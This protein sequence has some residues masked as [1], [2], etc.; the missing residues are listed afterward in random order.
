V[1]H[2]DM[3]AIRAY[4]QHK[5]ICG[6][7]WCPSCG[8]R[9]TTVADGTWCGACLSRF[10]KPCDCGLDTLLSSLTAAGE[11]RPVC[12][13]GEPLR[14]ET[15]I[16]G[17]HDGMWVCSADRRHFGML[18]QSSH[19]DG[20]AQE[21]DYNALYHELLLEVAKKYPG[22]SRHETARRYIRERETAPSNAA[23]MCKPT[24]SPVEEGQKHG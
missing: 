19:A 7:M 20:K 17:Q 12:S 1:T 21:P 9:G 18:L 6:S 14:F 5:H 13:C 24:P 22:E 15:A 23:Q 8:Y 10:S 3:E 16:N 2:Q 11:G 4:V